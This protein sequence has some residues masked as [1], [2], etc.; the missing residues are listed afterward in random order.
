MDYLQDLGENRDYF[1]NIVVED[2]VCRLERSIRTSFVIYLKESYK[3]GLL[4]P[5][6]FSQNPRRTL[7]GVIIVAPILRQNFDHPFSPIYAQFI[8]YNFTK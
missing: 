8:C 3:R 4:T 2:E 5:F 7:T 1:C 6:S